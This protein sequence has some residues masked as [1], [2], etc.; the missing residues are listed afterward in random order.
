MS[1]AASIYFETKHACN[2]N[3]A[4]WIDPPVDNTSWL[5]W[6]RNHASTLYSRGRN[7]SFQC[8]LHDTL[9]QY[10]GWISPELT[11]LSFHGAGRSQDGLDSL[12]KPLFC[13]SP[14]AIPLSTLLFLLAEPL[15]TYFL[16]MHSHPLPHR[17]GEDSGG[18]R[19]IKSERPGLRNTSWETTIRHLFWRWVGS[20]S[21]GK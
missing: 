21:I 3:C 17:A 9:A 16:H 8:V 6:R 10:R 13:F 20:L 1:K 5:R 11:K 14:F 2:L 19:T 12:H 4:Q 7:W 18:L 15:R